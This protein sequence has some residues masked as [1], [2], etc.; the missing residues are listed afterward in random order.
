MQSP[1]ALDAP[2]NILVPWNGGIPIEFVRD[3]ARSIGGPHAR[4]MLLPVA[5]GHTEKDLTPPA[6]APTEPTRESDWSRIEVL[7]RSDAVNPALEIVAVAARRDVD[8]ILM[9]TRCH[10]DGAIDAGCSAAQLALDSPTP[11]MVVHVDG[12]DLAAVSPHISRLV[13]PLDG[14]ARAAQ[15]LPFAASLARRLRL[16]VR[17]VMVIDPVRMLPPAYAYD[18]EASAQMLARLRN[19]AH[20]ALT[21]AELQLANEGVEVTSELLSGPVIPSIEAAVQMGDVLVMT[22]HGTGGDTQRLGSVA[23]RLL[24]DNPGPLV[25]MRGSPPA[26]VVVSGHGERG[27]Y[28]SFSRPTA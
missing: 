9:A 26:S 28:E 17:L 1:P 23:A 13:V 2:L 18:P 10:P 3:V 21:G 4:L 16:T 15:A 8:L 22:T 12:N 14:S 6:L 19:E 20:N 24:V 7:E 27:P 11:V 25:I 5:P